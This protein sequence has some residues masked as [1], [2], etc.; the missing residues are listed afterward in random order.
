MAN[1]VIKVVD[2]R[3]TVDDRL[4]IANGINTDT[5]TLE[6]DSEWGGMRVYVILGTGKT[7]FRTEW[8][9]IPLTIPAE[10]L[11]RPGY[12]PVS[13]IGVSSEKRL[14]TR[15]AYKALRVVASGTV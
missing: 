3:I 5:I 11:K 6:L 12:I 8:R 13:V 7:M 1:H 15:G 14:T 2:R 9:Y 4:I 10:L